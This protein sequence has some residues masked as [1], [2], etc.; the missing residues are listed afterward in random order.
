[1]IGLKDHVFSR[2][3]YLY[4]LFSLFTPLDATRGSSFF[5][6]SS[7]ARANVCL[8]TEKK[9]KENCHDG[10]TWSEMGKQNI[11][12]KEVYWLPIL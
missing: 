10:I 4:V 12:A 1:M 11:Q 2:P 9:Q 3:L 5:Q 7:D 6:M 8:N